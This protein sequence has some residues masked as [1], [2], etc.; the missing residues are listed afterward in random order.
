MASVVTAERFTFK[1]YL[2]QVNVNKDRFEAS[3]RSFAL[4]AED[5]AFFKKAAQSANG[6]AR[7]LVLGEDWCPDVVRGLPVMQ[8]VAE[9]AGVELRVFPRDKNLDIMNEFLNQGQFQSIPTCVFYAKDMKEIGRW[10]ERPAM[11]NREQAEA[12]AAIRKDKPGASEQEFRAAM[13][14]RIGS[15]TGAWQQETVK[16]TRALVGERLGI[17]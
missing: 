17:G 1:D 5:S 9:A 8:R 14:E 7:I 4:G 3:Y 6:L 15:R 12:A 11:A 16:E 13:R 2:A 10:I